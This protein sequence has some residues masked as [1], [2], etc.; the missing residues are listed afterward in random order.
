MDASLSCFLKCVMSFVCGVPQWFYMMIGASRT[1]AQ[2]QG[3]TCACFS[4]R[5]KIW[6]HL[7]LQCLCYG[8]DSAGSQVWFFD[9]QSTAQVRHFTFGELENDDWLDSSHG[10]MIMMEVG[11][12]HIRVSVHTWS[13]FWFESWSSHATSDSSHVRG[14]FPPVIRVDSSRWTSW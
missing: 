12:N 7:D 3:S 1:R 5:T 13:Q 6:H 9:Q 11:S 14:I 2:E 8:F 4:V 10:G